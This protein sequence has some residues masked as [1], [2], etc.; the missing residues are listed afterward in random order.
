MG[1]S[2]PPPP[3]VTQ[4]RLLLAAAALLWS[5][6]G[7]F[8]SVLT[9]DTSLGLSHPP[10]DS[11]S[12]AFYRVLFAGL[13]LLPTL[14][15]QDI[16]FRPVMA[17]MVACFAT[18]NALFVIALTRGTAADAILLQ[19]TAPM[20]MYLA[21]IWL[22]GEPPDRRSSVAVAIGL[23]GIAVILL[24]SFQGGAP[25]PVVAIGLGSGV[26]YAGVVLCLRVLRGVSPRWLTV[27][28]H[29]AGALVVLPLVWGLAAPTWPQLGV[30]FLFGTV[31]MALP[32]WLAARALQSVS[33]QEAGTITL[34]EPLLNPL[35]AYLVAGEVPS[36]FTFIGG[37]FIL[38][39]LVW[40]YWPFGK[41][42]PG[43]Q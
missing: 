18:M 17:V 11:L 39:A 2:P 23:A 27:V 37:V 7:A 16:S 5:L 20:W 19:Y 36:R 21:S 26:A 41:P 25:L 30:L 34:L 42:R 40:R 28:N 15:R 32:Y 35:W 13:V 29:L 12:I 14:R 8:K 31:Q 24:G 43:S 9:R 38:G 22:L 6:S 10:V 3:S 33:P 4:G 1:S